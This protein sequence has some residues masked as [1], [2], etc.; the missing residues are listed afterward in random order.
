MKDM[1]SILV[2]DRPEAVGRCHS[3][4]IFVGHIHHDSV[5]EDRI[6]KVESLRTIIPKDAWHADSG[7][8]SKR[9][10]KLIYFHREF[11]EVERY[12]VAVREAKQVGT[13]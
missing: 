4:H 3:R 12:T 8:R 9:D 13:S 7:Y 2:A 1:T 11:G 10:M 6:G 5:I